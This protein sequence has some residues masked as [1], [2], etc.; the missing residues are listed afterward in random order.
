MVI[1]VSSNYS[2]HVLHLNPKNFI[3]S[4]RRLAVEMGPAFELYIFRSRF[5]VLCDFASMK[6]ILLKRPKVF[7]RD[8]GIERAFEVVGLAKSS[9]FSAEGDTWRRLHRVLAPPLSRQSAAGMVPSVRREVDAM[10]R[11][12]EGTGGK[13]IPD[14]NTTMMQF[15]L[16][17]VLRVAFDPVEI[18]DHFVSSQILQDTNTLFAYVTERALSP[19]PGWL[20]RLCPPSIEKNMLEANA[21]I[22][23]IVGRIVDSE[24]AKMDQNQSTSNASAPSATTSSSTSSSTTI[25]RTKKSLIQIL[26]SE[27]ESAGTGPAQPVSAVAVAS[28]AVPFASGKLTPTPPPPPPTTTTTTTTTSESSTHGCGGKLTRGEVCANIKTMLLA[29]TETTSVSLVWALYHL[30]RS[31]ACFD[32]AREEADEAEAANTTATTATNTTNDTNTTATTADAADTAGASSSAMD[33][34]LLP[35]CAACFKEVQRFQGAVTILGASLVSESEPYTLPSGV[36][37]RPYDTVLFP[38]EHLMTDA[39]VFPD[40]LCFNPHRWLT[41]SS[42]Q[43]EKMDAVFLSFGYES[44]V[45]PGMHLAKL[46]GK[47]ALAHIVQNFDLHLECKPEEV[48]RVLQFTVR[49]ERIPMRF[50]KRV[51]V[52]SI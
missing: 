44:R 12:L 45:C 46:E 39:A 21:R 26:L 51:K 32:R 35:F 24:I 25:S 3:E 47:L 5:L 6:E 28:P 37:I 48:K 38:I 8:Y 31:K 40:P 1:N 9:L 15:T 11:E 23:D 10:L 41:S 7:R 33:T 17:T 42:A 4:I 50:V 43:L 36:E 2:G 22:D 49:A 27:S 16:R 34:A 19:L 20:W 30:S 18:D 14:I 13:T 52:A 29:G